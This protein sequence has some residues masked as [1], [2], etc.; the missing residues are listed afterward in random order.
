MRKAALY[1]SKDQPKKVAG[2][3]HGFK[4]PHPGPFLPNI[5]L[6]HCFEPDF[7]NCRTECLARSYPHLSDNLETLLRAKERERKQKVTEDI[8]DHRKVGYRG[9]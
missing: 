3:G 5:E 7:N 1:I 2:G 6:R 9:D 4:S 8:A